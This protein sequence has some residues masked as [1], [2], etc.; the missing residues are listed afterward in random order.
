MQ[1]T[2]SIKT[3]QISTKNWIDNAK[4]SFINW[5][6][7]LDLNSYKTVELASYFAVGLFVGFILKRHAKILFTCFIVL[8]VAFLFSTYFDLAFINWNKVRE[9][10]NISP[11]DTLGTLIEN[12][13]NWVKLNIILVISALLGTLTGY[14]IG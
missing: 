14:K 9:L 2:T 7:Q 12:C 4:D 11:N 6:N 13:I 5:Y 8:I 1:A 3:T 10:T